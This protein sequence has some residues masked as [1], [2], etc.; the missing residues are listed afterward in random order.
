MGKIKKEN[1]FL[2]QNSGSSLIEVV[3]SVAVI[4]FLVTAISTFVTGSSEQKVK[5]AYSAARDSIYNKAVAAI[6]NRQVLTDA[7][8]SRTFRNCWLGV[9]CRV[10][11]KSRPGRDLKILYTSNSN[12][13]LVGSVDDPAVYNRWGVNCGTR[14]NPR[15]ANGCT[16]GR[17]I[18]QV[19]SEY[20]F[21]CPDNQNRCQKP[22]SANL[23]VNV[24]LNPILKTG[25]PP[26]WSPFD[27]T[28]PAERKPE[29]WVNLVFQAR[30][31]TSYT[32]NICT[33]SGAYQSGLNAEGKPICRCLPTHRQTGRNSQGQPICRLIDCINSNLNSRQT[34]NFIG[35]DANG[36]PLCLPRAYR[37]QCSTSTN[38]NCQSR[39]WIKLF[40][41]GGC[42]RD[43][44]SS[45][46]GKKGGTYE[47]H[48]LICQ[49]DTVQ[50]CRWQK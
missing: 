23:R 7:T 21:T 50:C 27:R 46:G 35:Y 43:R 40:R 45:G 39:G 22:L 14:R 4:G 5:I 49:Q 13:V 42:M 33:S 25:S 31:I 30:A 20:W 34:T 36:R 10:T 32:N 19:Y 8:Q 3:I 11:N 6:S 2:K 9:D 37:I 12:T 17:H 16:N 24:V 38:S 48:R 41:L 1:I 26:A 29:Y 28:L 44:Q 47:T 15:R 18:W